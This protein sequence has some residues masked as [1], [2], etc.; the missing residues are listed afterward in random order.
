M[1]VS[2]SAH[3]IRAK[4]LRKLKGIASPLLFDRRDTPTGLNRMEPGLLQRLMSSPP[5]LAAQED[6]F[7]SLSEIDAD[8]ERRC[9]CI[10]RS[11]DEEHL[12]SSRRSRYPASPT[13]FR[14]PEICGFHGH[15]LI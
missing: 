15:I 9:L 1:D 4:R 14:G 3:G 10:Q 12:S 8:G 2:F 6:P 5:K 11:T 13:W 7:P